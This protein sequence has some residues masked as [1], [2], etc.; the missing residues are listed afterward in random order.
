MFP[1]S[2]EMLEIEGWEHG[3]EAE[4]MCIQAFKKHDKNPTKPQT[5]LVSKM[6]Y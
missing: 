2:L 4:V 5:V 1:L 6:S 3:R